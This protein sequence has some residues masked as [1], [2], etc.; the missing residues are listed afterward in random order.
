MA[1]SKVQNAPSNNPTTSQPQQGSRQQPGEHGQRGISR[2]EEYFPSRDLFSLSPFTMMRR[3][4]EEMDR[5][6][7]SSFGL[8]PRLAES[9]MWAPPIEVRERNNQLEIAAE[10]P[11]LNKDDVRVECTENGIV[12]EGEKK[13]ESESNEGGFHRSERSYGHFYRVIPLPEGAN[14]EQAKAEF[15]DGVL[16]IRVPIEQRQNKNRQIP[17]NG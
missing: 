2:R 13:R 17:I 5:A 3:L 6:F 4:S 7:A 12:I 10:L 16:N 8:S 14:A 9:G 15:K 11:G 1:E